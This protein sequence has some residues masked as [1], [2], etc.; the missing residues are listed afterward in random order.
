MVAADGHDELAELDAM[1]DRFFVF[2]D[3]NAHRV[4]DALLDLLVSGR[5]ARPCD[6]VQRAAV[7]VRVRVCMHVCVVCG[8]VHVRCALCG[9]RRPAPVSVVRVCS[10]Q[11]AP[12]GHTVADT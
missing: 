5:C 1:L 9:A 7:C 2:H 6:R 3:N 8:S 10:A 11:G 4:M 12:R